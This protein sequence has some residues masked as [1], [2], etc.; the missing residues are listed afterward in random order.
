ML[1]K[2]I[3]KL[4][5]E[6]LRYENTDANDATRSAFDQLALPDGHKAMV[7]SL[8][9]QHFRARQ[10]ASVREEQTD[11]VRGKGKLLLDQ[12]NTWQN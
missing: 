5:L 10:S 2:S 12:V 3:A 9:T 4:D 6:F 11:L 7:K 8:V 1:T